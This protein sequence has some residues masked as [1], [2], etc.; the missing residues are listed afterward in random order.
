MFAEFINGDKPA[1]LFVVFAADLSNDLAG[2]VYIPFILSP[3]FWMIV[4]PL[5]VYCCRL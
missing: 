4:S 2:S 3:L 5:F 1:G